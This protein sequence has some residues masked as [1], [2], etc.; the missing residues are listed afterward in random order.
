[1]STE[2]AGLERAA[3]AMLRTLGAGK[4]SLLVPQPAT[5]NAQ[6]GLG[7]GVPLVNEV[8][9]EPVLLQTAVTGTTLLALMTRCTVQKAINSAGAIDANQTLETSMLRAGGTQYR[10]VSVTVKRFGGG[11]LLYELEIEA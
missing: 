10:I 2:V 9:M 11:E 4:A 6:V 7:L 3:I 1:M 8:E 5:A